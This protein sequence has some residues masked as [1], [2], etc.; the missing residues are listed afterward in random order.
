MTL[1]F[2]RTVR[3]FPGVRLNFSKSGI[4]AS[5][6]GSPFTVNVG[7]RGL[8]STAG[9]PGTG[10]SFRHHVGTRSSQGYPAEVFPAQVPEAVV[11]EAVSEPGNEI[12]SA[13]PDRVTSEGLSALLDLL[14]QANAERR[15]IREVLASAEEELDRRNERCERWKDGFFLRRLFRGR[16]AKLEKEAAQTAAEVSELSRQLEQA[17]IHTQIDIPSAM[18]EEYSKACEAFRQLCTA[19]AIWDV[20]SERHIDTR[21]ERSS[22]T[23]S[24]AR[25]R[26]SFEI[27]HSDLITYSSTVPVLRNKNGG[28]LFLYPAFILYRVSEFDFGLVDLRELKV[29]ITSAQ[30]AETDALPGDAMRVGTTWQKVNADGGPDRRFRDNAEM[31]MMEYGILR[32]ASR[33]GLHE[34]YMVSN[35]G[36]SSGFGS[37]LQRLISAAD[38]AGVSPAPLRV[39]AAASSEQPNPQPDGS[40]PLPD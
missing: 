34:E 10:I 15:Q 2:R 32:L 3:L 35:A 9:I 24:V 23:R 19:S 39:P 37:A 31:P 26:V 14:R 28:D 33:G 8:M 6:G 1:R 38:L 12:R 13:S 11:P 22:V 29:E 40:A 4:S 5:I 18:G 30:F 36:L 27:G 25:E 20:V 21:R 16:T 17:T 7:P